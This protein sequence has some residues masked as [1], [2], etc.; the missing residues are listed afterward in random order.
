[1]FRQDII[2]LNKCSL[3]DIV[4][5]PQINAVTYKYVFTSRNKQTV[6][7]AFNSYRIFS[8]L[9]KVD[10]SVIEPKLFSNK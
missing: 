7:H 9:F 4:Y 3:Q 6:S 2:L 10:S 1:M 8:R 5:Y